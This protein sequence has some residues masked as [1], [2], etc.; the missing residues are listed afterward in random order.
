MIILYHFAQK[1]NSFPISIFDRDTSEIL[2]GFTISI[3]N[4]IS[5]EI[6]VGLSFIQASVSAGNTLI[7]NS[8]LR[9]EILATTRRHP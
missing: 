4:S 8:V 3:S 1:L 7:A 9:R 5:W 2:K 6:P